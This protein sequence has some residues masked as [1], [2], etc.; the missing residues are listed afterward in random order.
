[1]LKPV[2]D[3]E[4]AHNASASWSNMMNRMGDAWTPAEIITAYRWW[5]Y[6]GRQ[7]SKE[8]SYALWKFQAPNG[9]YILLG[10]KWWSDLLRAHTAL[11]EKETRRITQETSLS[12]LKTLIAVDNDACQEAQTYNEI[13]WKLDAYKCQLSSILFLWIV[14]QKWQEPFSAEAQLRIL[15]DALNY[16]QL[17]TDNEH[18]SL[19]IQ[20]IK[21]HFSVYRG[22]LLVDTDTFIKTLEQ[23]ESVEV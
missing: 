7:A 6:G 3:V 5:I 12:T 19:C 16:I 10:Y 14:I 8:G 15:D 4:A 2:Y 18:K 23:S 9:Y 22:N 17:L 1:M 20:Y 11:E 21:L 13:C